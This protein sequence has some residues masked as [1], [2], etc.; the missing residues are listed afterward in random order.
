MLPEVGLSCV[1][2]IRRN[3][4]LPAPFFPSSVNIL[5][6]GMLRLT[7]ESASFDDLP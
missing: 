1:A 3:V 5:E 4:V 6:R 2:A 7:L